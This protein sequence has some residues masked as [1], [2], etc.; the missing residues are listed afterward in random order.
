MSNRPWCIVLAVASMAGCAGSRPSDTGIRIG[1][2]T[3]DQFE[4]GITT[5]AWLVA[6]LGEP[7]S[8][9]EVEG[10]KNTKVFRYASGESASGLSSLFAG[11]SSRTTAVTYFIISE[12]IVTRF[13]ADRATEYTLLGKPVEQPEG[14]KEE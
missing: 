6:V 10:V 9:C 14:E 7:T 11:N 5:E 12:G 13:W 2:E 8:S 3:L 4:A 1:D